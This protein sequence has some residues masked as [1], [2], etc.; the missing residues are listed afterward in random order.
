[1]ALLAVSSLRNALLNDHLSD[2]LEERRARAGFQPAPPGD[3]G[4]KRALRARARSSISGS[5]GRS[6]REGFAHEHPTLRLTGRVDFHLTG[7][8]IAEVG[9]PVLFQAGGFASSTSYP[10]VVVNAGIKFRSGRS[11]LLNEAAV[12]LAKSDLLVACRS[13]GVDA[14]ILLDRAER[15]G[16]VDFAGDDREV[17]AATEAATAWVRLA[18]AEGVGFDCEREARLELRPNMGV[19]S[20]NPAVQ[21][22]K[23]ALAC[24]RRELTLLWNVGV[25]E[26][27]RAL[28]QGVSTYDDPRL[29]AGMLGIH[30]ERGRILDRII[31]ANRVES[32]PRQIARRPFPGCREGDAFLDLETMGNL[33]KGAPDFV[34]MIGVGIGEDAFSLYLAE[35]LTL[36]AEARALRAFYAHCTDL[37]VRRLLH[38]G[39]HEATVFRKRIARRHASLPPDLVF[40]DMCEA[41]KSVDWFPPGAFNYSL[42]SIVPAMHEAGMI[43]INWTSDCADGRTAMES[44]YAAYA[45][46]DQAV[47]ADIGEYNR[48]DVVATMQI[49]RYLAA[50]GHVL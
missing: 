47:L 34:F 35:D 45:S 7:A 44:A 10:V 49:W 50:L 22:E 16:L 31:A 17:E 23:V 29:T 14:G 24:R 3:G 36:E 18:S 12:R 32:P 15:W 1:M 41:L 40:L 26:R 38:W 48:V 46:N 11:T 9:G 21:K 13:M 19:L 28:T 27:A 42:K 30:G 39:A 33:V 8:E 6:V 43:D 2:V 5:L 37:G 25:R 4:P 20:S